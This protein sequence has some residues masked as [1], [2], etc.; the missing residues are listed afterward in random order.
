MRKRS[1]GGNAWEIGWQISSF[2]L[3]QLVPNKNK[4]VHSEQKW[5]KRRSI[6]KCSKNGLA[7]LQS[8]PE[9]KLTSI[10]IELDQKRQNVVVSDVSRILTNAQTLMKDDARLISI[11]FSP[12][13]LI[14][15]SFS[16]N[17]F[18]FPSLSSPLSANMCWL[19]Q[20]Y[21]FLGRSPN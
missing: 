1:H 6:L 3:W 7:Y 17:P 20:I 14:R 18:P 12:D 10:S 16:R 8:L 2:V 5:T 13:A 19:G 4:L 9:N 11:S 21:F 15:V